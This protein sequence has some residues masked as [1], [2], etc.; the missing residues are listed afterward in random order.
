MSYRG[1]TVL[2]VSF[3]EENN[4]GCTDTRMYVTD[5]FVDQMEPNYD[6]KDESDDNLF[7]S[8]SDEDGGNQDASRAATRKRKAEV[9]QQAKTGYAEYGKGSSSW[10]GAQYSYSNGECCTYS[11]DDEEEPKPFDEF[12]DSDPNLVLG[13][14][15]MDMV[16]SALGTGGSARVRL[17]RI[18]DSDEVVAIKVS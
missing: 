3:T 16:K 4:V 12:E 2:F 18:K 17:G 7:G 15:E 8:D 13:K 9:M 11:S 6:C 5:S 10:S 1:C 14:Y